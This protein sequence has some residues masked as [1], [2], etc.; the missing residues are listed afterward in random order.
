MKSK[1]W[2]RVPSPAD[3]R[4]FDGLH[5]SSVYRRAVADRWR[6]PSCARTATE[7]I[8]WSEV[9]GPIFR[10]RYADEYGMGFTISFANHHCHGDGRFETI[11]ICG[12]CNAADGAVKRKLKLPKTWSFAAD[13]IKQFIQVG[14][15]SGRTTI[16]Y[17]KAHEIWA[18]TVKDL[19]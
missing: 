12:D 2:S 6:C 15:H 13:E 7:L 1:K 8:R 3:I 19:T 9:R 14:P 11:L 18:A 10:E 5:C 17:D 16:D 4:N